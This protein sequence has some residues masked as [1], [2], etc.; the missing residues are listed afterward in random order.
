MSS[1]ESRLDN[2]VQNY[3][4][5]LKN[6]EN[7]RMLQTGSITLGI[8]KKFL[9][10][11]YFIEDLSQKA[12]NRAAENTS[13]S[14]PYLSKRFEHC[15]RGELGHAEIALKDLKEL[16]EEGIETESRGLVQEYLDFLLKEADEYPLGILGHSYLFENVS[17][18]MFPENEPL[19]YPSKFIEVHA[20][21]DPGHSIALKRTVRNIEDD[22]SQDNIDRII[23]F[24]RKSGEYLIKVF[25][26]C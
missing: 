13:A 17:G 19:E 8:Y 5:I 7:V 11:F 1:L 10:T 12:V 23:K 25:E 16:G 2:E 26:S 24:S 18:I 22:L 9:K 6:N 21:E 3:L 15:A 4:E 14:N 20:K